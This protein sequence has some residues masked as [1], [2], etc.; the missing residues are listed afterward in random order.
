MKFIFLKFLIAHLLGDFVFQP[1][2]WILDKEKRKLKSSKLYLHILVHTLCLLTVFLFDTQYIGGYILIIISH[3]LIDVGKLYVQSEKTK[4]FIF[5][6]DQ[7]LHIIM[8][9][10]A[11]YLYYP[12]EIDFST[13]YSENI[14]LMIA[15][16]IFAT[17]VTSI[18]ITNLLSYWNI[19]EVFKNEESLKNA[20]KYI[21]ILERLF[22]F[23]F[24]A[25]GKWE[26]VGFLIAAKSVFR[27]GDLTAAKNR[28]LT[29]YVLIGTL[30]SFGLAILTGFVYTYYGR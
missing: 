26:G 10:I 14:L 16:I 9:G 18:I 22:I 12:F 6:I 15:C 28:K 8:I 13:I 30:L 23:A 1:E 3:F 5:F 7:I 27:F 24:I 2:K 11:T 17:F 19:E 21:G 25:M 29:E 4:R 20:G